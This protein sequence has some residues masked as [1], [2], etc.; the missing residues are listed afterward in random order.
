MEC[1]DDERWRLQS[2]EAVVSWLTWEPTRVEPVLL[3]KNQLER[4]AEVLCGASDSYVVKVMD[5][6]S[7]LVKR[8]PRVTAALAR[9]RMGKKLVQYHLHNRDVSISLQALKLLKAMY[10]SHPSHK[11]LAAA[12]DLQS[13]LRSLTSSGETQSAVLARQL[14]QQLLSALQVNSFI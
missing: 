7:R 3:Q 8:A 13:Q 9:G 2:L 6:L 14:A 11:E 5:L 4:L 12:L 10:E 1:L